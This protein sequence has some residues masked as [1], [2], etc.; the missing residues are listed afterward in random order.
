MPEIPWAQGDP[1]VTPET[2]GAD[3]EKAQVILVWVKAPGVGN[4]THLRGLGIMKVRPS[5]TRSSWRE[6]S[7]MLKNTLFGGVS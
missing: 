2:C 3:G 7:R 6:D 4:A 5:A 1:G